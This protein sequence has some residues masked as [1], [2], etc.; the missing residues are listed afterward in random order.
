MEVMSEG[1]TCRLP[2]QSLPA[3]CGERPLSPQR[4][5]GCVPGGG[6]C[7]LLPS[8]PPA[9]REWGLHRALGDLGEAT[10]EFTTQQTAAI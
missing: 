8:A 5:R 3:P 7:P 4:L 1:G 10:P 9:R 2:A 6:P